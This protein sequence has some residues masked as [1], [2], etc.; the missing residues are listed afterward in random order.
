MFS[1][2]RKSCSF[3]FLCFL[4]KHRDQAGKKGGREKKWADGLLLLFVTV[5]NNKSGGGWLGGKKKEGI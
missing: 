5:S 3:S 2:F 1:A 4:L